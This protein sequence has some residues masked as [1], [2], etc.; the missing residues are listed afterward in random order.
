MNKIPEEHASVLTAFARLAQ[1]IS[2]GDGGVRIMAPTG[3]IGFVP[4]DK[5]DEAIAAGAT[6]MTPEK[7]RELRQEVFM[8]HGLFKQEHAKPEPRRRKSLVKSKRRSR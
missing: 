6:V 5:L 8:E 1:F 3:Q 7:M 2:P 4:A